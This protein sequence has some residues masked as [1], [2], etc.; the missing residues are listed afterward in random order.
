MLARTKVISQFL[1]DRINHKIDLV[2]VT[3]NLMQPFELHLSD[4]DIIEM[5]EIPSLGNTSKSHLTVGYI[6]QLAIVIVPIDITNNE[7]NIPLW[8][9]ICSFYKD[10]IL[11]IDRNTM[12]ECTQSHL[13]KI[14]ELISSKATTI[15]FRGLY[16]P[17]I[18]N[19]FIE[20]NIPIKEALLTDYPQLNIA[21]KDYLTINR[22]I[23]ELLNS[24]L[25]KHNQ[26]GCYILEIPQNR[27]DQISDFCKYILTCTVSYMLIRRQQQ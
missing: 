16:A 10:E 6:D 2:I 9:G 4:S 15:P 25:W 8:D 11:F 17:L 18:E 26:L 5:S 1:Q 20:G 27:I 7:E 23:M 19:A 21:P 22:N 3:S 13:L 14:K 24:I 12:E